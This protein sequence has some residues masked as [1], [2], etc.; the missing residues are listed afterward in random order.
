LVKRAKKK[1]FGHVDKNVIFGK[2]P[3]GDLH[4]TVLELSVQ[5]ADSESAHTNAQAR[6]F[7]L[8]RRTLS[9]SPALPA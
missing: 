1:D 4:L 6:D 8:K 9:Q 3:R 2:M 5:S 7:K